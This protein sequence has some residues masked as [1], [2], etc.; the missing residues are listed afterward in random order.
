MR[1][2]ELSESSENYLKA[3]YRLS[4][5]EKSFV[6]PRLLMKFLP[7][8]PSTITITLQRLA[9]K[10]YIVYEKYHGVRLT[11]KGRVQVAK[12]LRRHRIFEVFLRSKLNLDL[13]STHSEACRVEHVLSD[14]TI[15][16]LEEFL[17]YPELCPH[18]NPIPDRNLNIVSLDDEPLSFMDP[19][20]YVLS[21]ISFETP[22]ILRKLINIGVVPNARIVLV[23]KI[24]KDTIIIRVG[25][26]EHEIPEYIARI[27]RVK[28]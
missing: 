1:R 15:D 18:G 3:I 4:E 28:K 11:E 10:G 19:G 13:I 6:K 24:P 25:G 8:A 20:E 17:G 2:N 27:L 7:Y 22:D 16:K 21:R 9:R 26:R 12:I 14:S 23:S 5:T